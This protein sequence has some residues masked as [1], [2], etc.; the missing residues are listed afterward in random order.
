MTDPDLDDLWSHHNSSYS[1]LCM[2]TSKR[3]IIV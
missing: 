2:L 3:L 1:H